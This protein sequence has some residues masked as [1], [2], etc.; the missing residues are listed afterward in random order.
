MASSEYELHPGKTFDRYFISYQKTL[1]SFLGKLWSR[2]HPTAGKCLATVLIF[3][4]GVTMKGD[5]LLILSHLARQFYEYPKED[6]QESSFGLMSQLQ[7]RFK[8]LPYYILTSVTQ[9]LV[10]Y[11]G[12]CGFLQWYFYVRQRDRP[13]EWKCQ[14]K[15]FLS[16]EDEK[17][18]I[19]L[20]TACM[21]MGSVISGF[22]SCW[23][24][25]GGY[26]ALYYNIHDYGIPYLVLSIP[27]VYL[28]TEALFYYYHRMFHL[29]AVYKAYHKYHHRYK[30]PTAFSSTA[31]HPL[32]F[33]ILQ[34]AIFIPMFTI[35]VHYAIF[36]GL[37]LYEYYYSVIGHSGVK[38]KAL[39]PWQPDSM[40]HDNHHEFFHVNFGLNTKLFDYLHDTLRKEDRI[41]SESIFFGHGKEWAAATEEEKQEF[42]R[43]HQD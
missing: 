34:S 10:L 42:L 32:E 16:W 1:Y 35:P 25:N 29:P 33:V 11:F 30:Q 38:I 39:W 40:F 23:T 20:G 9:S 18:A 43:N 31:M 22:L 6:S 5:W 8:G 26:T 14:P 2:L 17:H 27:L 37:V 13:E 19:I 36:I 24:M 4:A 21:F 12:L 41:Y 15:K 3:L 7:L 28:V